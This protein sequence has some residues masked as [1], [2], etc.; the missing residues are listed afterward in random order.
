MWTSS[1]TAVDVPRKIL[2]AALRLNRRHQLGQQGR[3]IGDAVD[4][5]AF[6][7]GVC[8]FAYRAEP[9]QCRHTH[10]SR[11]IPVRPAAG[12]SSI[13]F[14]TAIPSQ[15]KVMRIRQP[16]LLP[17][18][19]DPILAQVCGPSLKPTPEQEAI[20]RRWREEADRRARERLKKLYGE[21]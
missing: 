9:I 10:R 20:L 18:E 12:A 5:Q 3:A 14:R 11:E 13:R 4:Q 1:Q 2:A 21:R 15:D 8:A 6:V 16:A 19:P 17:A 7:G